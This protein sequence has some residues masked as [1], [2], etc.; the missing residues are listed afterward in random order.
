MPPE[1]AA[2]KKNWQ[3]AQ[4]ARLNDGHDADSF[5]YV[6]L[7]ADDNLPHHVGMGYTLGRPWEMKRSRSS[8]H[9]NKVAKHGI[10]I[11]I[12]ADELSKEAAKFWEIA[13]IKALKVSGY[14]STN[15]TDGGDGTRGLPAHNRR[16]VLCLETGE[17]F[18]SAT[19]A[20][21]KFNISN[22]A[23]SDV[24]NLKY[25]SVNEFHFIYSECKIDEFNR[26]KKIREI[27]KVCASRRKKVEKNKSYDGVKDGL[28]NKG[29]SAAGP[30]KNS[31]KVLCLDDGKIYQSASEAARIYNVARSAVIELC[32]GK[33][34]RQSVGGFKFKYVEEA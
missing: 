1:A 31:R 33:N 12:V 23:V 6:H 28:D 32:L 16:K 19:K 10:R 25:R 17:L 24:C 3:K 34:N 30:M 15:L 14:E 9:K 7:N 8:K 2:Y 11:E 27:E 21:N 29:R 22:I 13:W 20:A 4:R 5:V 26:F 18:S